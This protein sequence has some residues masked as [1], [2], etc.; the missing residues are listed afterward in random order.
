MMFERFS[1]SSVEGGNVVG[2]DIEE[3][4]NGES[5][6]GRVSEAGV[7]LVLRI[8]WSPSQILRFIKMS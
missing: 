6:I 8:L 5:N 7:W 1:K 4:S 2:D 3:N